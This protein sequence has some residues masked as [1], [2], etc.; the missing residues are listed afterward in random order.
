MVN[1]LQANQNIIDND[2]KIIS[3]DVWENLI[4]MITD[5][6]KIIQ[7]KNIT[8]KRNKNSIFIKYIINLEQIYNIDKKNIIKDFSNY[9][10]RSYPQIISE[11]F[12]RTLENIMHFED[13]DNNYYVNYYFYK[14]IDFLLEI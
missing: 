5:K 6:N 7:K 14:L 4:K 12:L 11:N 8:N 13:C 1:F 3:S 10:V 9:L 2:I